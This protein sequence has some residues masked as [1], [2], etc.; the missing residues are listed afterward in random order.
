MYISNI[1][2]KRKK[3]SYKKFYIPIIVKK[4]AKI[5]RFVLN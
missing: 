4:I 2:S 1:N 5:D 3:N